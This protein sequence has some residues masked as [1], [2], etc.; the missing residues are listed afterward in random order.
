[1]RNDGIA[2]LA[3]PG[4]LVTALARARLDEL[5]RLASYWGE[6]LAEANELELTGADHLTVVESAARLARSAGGS[7]LYCWQW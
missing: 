5:R 3:F 7:G 4:E 6:R 2:V 1:M